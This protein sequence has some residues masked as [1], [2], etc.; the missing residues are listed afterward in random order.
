M[1]VG[2]YSMLYTVVVSERRHSM[3]RRQSRWLPTVGD[4]GDS[5]EISGGTIAP[6][7]TIGKNGRARTAALK[8]KKSLAG[9]PVLVEVP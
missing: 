4:S 9:P 6:R 3:R 8:R 1:Q 7:F 2:T 5:G